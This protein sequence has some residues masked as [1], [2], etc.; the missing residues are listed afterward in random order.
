V[1]ALPADPIAVRPE[2]LRPVHAPRHASGRRR[3]G[4][5]PLPR[6]AVAAEARS[7]RT[8]GSIPAH[9][10]LPAREAP[11]GRVYCTVVRQAGC[12]GA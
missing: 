4:R 11:Q 9:S 1:R 12:G 3:S 10:A 5:R 2:R 6:L 8:D 7:R